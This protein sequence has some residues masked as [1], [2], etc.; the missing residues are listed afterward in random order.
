[1]LWREAIENGNYL[2]SRKVSDRDC[3]RE[4]AGI[5]IEA[6][7]VKIDEQAVMFFWSDAERSNHA[8]RDT[9]DGVSG[10]IH[11]IK[12]FRAFADSSLP[13][14]GAGPALFERLRNFRVRFDKRQRF[15]RFRTD[16]G[17]HGHDAG[18]V[19]GTVRGDLAAVG[20]LAIA[21]RLLCEHGT[22]R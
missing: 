7:A 9:S 3:F 16:R 22:D 12:F 5:G 20:L 17:R 13:S 4:R 1:M 15:L 2:Y 14:V 8:N 19:C 10:D 6:A 18:D 21:G 11:R